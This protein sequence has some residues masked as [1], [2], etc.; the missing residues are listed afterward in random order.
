[1]HEKELY[2]GLYLRLNVIYDETVGLQARSLQ[3][4]PSTTPFLTK[5]Y[6]EI[7]SIFVNKSLE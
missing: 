3:P 5:K 4:Q 6:L 7:F 2:D 1:L